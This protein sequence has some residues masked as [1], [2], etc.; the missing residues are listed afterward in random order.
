MRGG[1]LRYAVT[2]EKIWPGDKSCREAFYYGDQLCYAHQ[3]AHWNKVVTVDDLGDDELDKHG[4]GSFSFTKA[5]KRD[6]IWH[7]GKVLF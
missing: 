2:F 5:R 4:S 6:V 3:F 7:K 1:M